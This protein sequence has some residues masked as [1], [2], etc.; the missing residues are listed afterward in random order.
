MRRLI[1]PT[2]TARSLPVPTAQVSMFTRMQPAISSVK[3]PRAAQPPL[4]W[5]RASPPY[6]TTPAELSEERP[7]P[8]S[9]ILRLRAA[10][11]ITP[12]RST[13]ETPLF[14]R[15]ISRRATSMFPTQARSAPLTTLFMLSVTKLR[16]LPFITM[17]TRA[18]TRP[19]SP[20]LMT[21]ST[22]TSSL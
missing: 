11:Y 21:D 10:A 18:A 12:V 7:A 4:R 16:V 5:F 22:R 1:P 14:P 9:R 3:T 2:A 19:R 20:V 6:R 13:S 17:L 15:T 8:P